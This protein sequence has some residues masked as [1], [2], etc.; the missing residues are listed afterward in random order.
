MGAAARRIPSS[1]ETRDS[2]D[3]SPVPQGQKCLRSP[4]LGVEGKLPFLN[5]GRYWCN[6]EVWILWNKKEKGS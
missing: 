4:S 2:E 1:F 3:V 5:L 6:R